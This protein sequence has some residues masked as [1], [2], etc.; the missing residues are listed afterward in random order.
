MADPLL[1]LADQQARMLSMQQQMLDSLNLA[2]T[3]QI[4]DQEEL[5]LLAALKT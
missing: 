2:S 3:Q 5:T 4:D 1:L